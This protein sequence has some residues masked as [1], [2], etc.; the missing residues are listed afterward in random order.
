MRR[1][2]GRLPD[3]EPALLPGYSAYTVNGA[4][5]PAIVPEPHAET[6]GLIYFGLTPGELKKLDDYEGGEYLR[7]RQTV[8]LSSGQRKISAWVYVLKPVYRARLSGKVWTFPQINADKI[9]FSVE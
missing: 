1:L 9:Q 8:V 2:I 3:G 4:N 6:A 5:Y 7:R